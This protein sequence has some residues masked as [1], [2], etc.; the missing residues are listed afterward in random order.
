MRIRGLEEV[1][2][3]VEEEAN[4]IKLNCFCFGEY[5]FRGT[6]K[7]S[8]T[9]SHVK[10]SL[11]SGDNE[12]D[13]KE[14]NNSLIVELNR[15]T[16]EISD[17]EAQLQDKTIANAEMS[18]SWNKMKVTPHTWPQVRQSA[19]AK[20]HH[21]NAPRPSRYSSIQV[22]TSTPKESVGSNDMVQNCYL[23]EAKKKAQLQKDKVLNSK[24]SVQKTARLPNTANGS[25]PKPRKSYQ[26]PRN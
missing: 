10:Q 2:E 26:Q 23:E 9:S 5:P 12:K 4:H 25:K 14:Q 21:V 17:L 20:P 6:C 22:S 3:E 16:L 1:E 11:K 19:F 13:L 8:A 15:K 18:E 24:P 7:E